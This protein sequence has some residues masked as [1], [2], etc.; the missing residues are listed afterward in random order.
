MQEYDFFERAIELRPRDTQI[1]HGEQMRP[2]AITDCDRII[3][4]KGSIEFQIGRNYILISLE[5]EPF[6]VSYLNAPSS[7]DYSFN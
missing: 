2:F 1:W 6:F 7:I 5:E 4:D 3:I